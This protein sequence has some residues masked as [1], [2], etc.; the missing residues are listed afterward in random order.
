MKYIKIC[1]KCGS[2]DITIPPAGLDLRMTMPDYCKK[3]GNRGI[4]PEIEKDNV[5]EFRKKIKR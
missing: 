5:E 2:T 3:C 1:L 4:F